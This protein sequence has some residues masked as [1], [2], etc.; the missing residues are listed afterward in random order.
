MSGGH[1]V[2]VA[3]GGVTLRGQG[4]SVERCE[5]VELMVLSILGLTRGF[6]LLAGKKGRGRINANICKDLS[7]DR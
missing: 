4:V 2:V 5:G 7:W 1:R 6:Q 3:A